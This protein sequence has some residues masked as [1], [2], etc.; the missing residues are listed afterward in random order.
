MKSFV[1]LVQVKS[2][3]FIL[4]YVNKMRMILANDLLQFQDILNIYLPY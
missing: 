1:R 4:V 2:G 3:I